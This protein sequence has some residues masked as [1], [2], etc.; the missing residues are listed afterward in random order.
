VIHDYINILA[1]LEHI[2]G[3]NYGYIGLL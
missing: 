2:E 3:S 1:Q